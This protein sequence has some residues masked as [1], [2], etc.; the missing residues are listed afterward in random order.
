MTVWSDQELAQL[1]YV[2]ISTTVRAT[3]ITLRSPGVAKI[4]G[5]GIP[6]DWDVRGGF[7]LAGATQVFR[8]LGLAEFQ[9]AVRVWETEHRDGFENFDTAIE[10]SLPGQP[11]RV[12]QIKHP[13][14]ALRG[15]SKCVF[16]NAPFLVPDDDGSSTASYK[17]RQWRKPLA[18]LL[19]PTAP[20][21][22][23]EKGR[24][25]DKYEQRAAERAGIL[26][27][28]FQQLTGGR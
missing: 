12:Y 17:C 10:P 2:E 4:T 28:K 23:S 26:D 1:D 25:A 27:K 18:T 15:I 21:D 19:S 24:A 22:A 11:E 8:G 16:L 7:G 14:L 9:V 3:P 6:R 13:M 20:G 5:D